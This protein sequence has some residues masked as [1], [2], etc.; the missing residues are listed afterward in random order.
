[1]SHWDSIKPEWAC[2]HK[3]LYF[4]RSRHLNL[5][6]NLRSS[7]IN[8]SGKLGSPMVTSLNLLSYSRFPTSFCF[9]FSWAYIPCRLRRSCCVRLAT[10]G[11]WWCT[12]RDGD[13]LG[14]MGE[15][16]MVHA[17]D[18]WRLNNM[19]RDEEI[20]WARCWGPDRSSSFWQHKSHHIFFF[21]TY[22]PH[23]LE[24][25]EKGFFTSFLI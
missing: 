25:D 8:K 22:Q 14:L 24:K 20:S 7:Y 19:L 10:W 13:C 21:A 9:Y 6:G 18:L 23:W 5:C 4:S 15:A 3:V 16:Y 2:R 1:M 11:I 17:K 12:I